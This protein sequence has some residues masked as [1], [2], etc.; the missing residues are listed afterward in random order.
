MNGS[1]VLLLAF[2]IGVIA[3]LRAI[4]APAVVAWA[5]H[6]SWINLHGTPLSFMGSI[7]AVAIFTLAAIGEIVN[8]KLPKTPSRL[9]PGGLAP[10]ILFGGLSGAAM[11]VGGGQALWLGIVLG[12]VGSLAG[13]F[14]GY[15]IR[16]S[17]VQALGTKDLYIALVED[18][19]AIG[20]GL[21]IVSHL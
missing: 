19:V 20:C 12:I 13:A 7:I 8:D 11:A 10:R 4:T 5:A 9:S 6:L 17:I 3:G 21:F 18:L 1:H 2:A 15:H 16:K 14:A